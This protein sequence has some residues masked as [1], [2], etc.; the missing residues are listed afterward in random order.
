MGQLLVVIASLAALQAS[1]AA[2]RIDAQQRRD[3]VKS[4]SSLL[5][6]RYLY[7]PVAKRVAE[8]LQGKLDRG[9]A[10]GLRV[11]GRALLVGERTGGGGHFVQGFRLLPHGFQMLLPVGRNLDPRTGESWEGAGLVPDVAVNPEQALQAAIG[12]LYGWRR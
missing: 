3:I 11:N 12:H 8:V 7:E 10:L 4:I 6:E 2:P 9:F 5:S 1:S